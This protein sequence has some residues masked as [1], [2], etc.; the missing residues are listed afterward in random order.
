MEKALE[1]MMYEKKHLA[2]NCSDLVNEMASMSE[3]LYTLKDS[4][5]K[6]L[7]GNVELVNAISDLEEEKKGLVRG[8]ADLVQALSQLATE[9]KQLKERKGKLVQSS[10]DLVNEIARLDSELK[11]QFEWKKR[12]EE[13]QK[14]LQV[15]C[16]SKR[17]FL[18]HT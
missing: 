12:S 16:K 6:L 15:Q 4:K 14:E 18:S 13:L 11:A 10:A 9:V 3:E 8:G 2:R 17:V 5:Q 1:N 7:S